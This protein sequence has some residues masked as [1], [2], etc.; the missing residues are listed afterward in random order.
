MEYKVTVEELSGWITSKEV[1]DRKDLYILRK[2]A[3]KNATSIDWDTVPENYTHLIYYYEIGDIVKVLNNPR[4]VDD[5]QFDEF[6]DY[7][8]PEFVGARHR[9]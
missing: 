1:T 8:H 3:Q 4:A 6:V 2:E 7:W 9:R 5:K